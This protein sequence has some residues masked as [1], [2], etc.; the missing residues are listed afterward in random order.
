MIGFSG[1]HRTDKPVDSTLGRV[2][3]QSCYSE[4]EDYAISRHQ[5]LYQIIS[6]Q[7]ASVTRSNQ[8]RT[9]QQAVIEE[10]SPKDSWM[11]RA[12]R[13]INAELR[14]GGRSRPEWR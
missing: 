7:G 10:H 2:M 6:P 5:F 14:G 13:S 4:G 9:R 1:P 11:P 8:N 3:I 12:L